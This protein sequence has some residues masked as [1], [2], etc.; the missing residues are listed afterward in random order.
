[1][2]GLIKETNENLKAI[3]NTM[4]ENLDT[5]TYSL[6][7]LQSQM[8]KKVEEAKKYKIQVDNAKENIKRIEEDNTNL[9][10]SLNELTD[11]YSKLN[12]VNII[13]AGN[14]EIK[15]KINENIKEIN[16]N[17][18]HIA[19]LTNKAR[20][21]KDLLINLK[22]DKNIK[23]ERLENLRIAYEFY[24][25]NLNEIIE[26]TYNNPDSLDSLEFHNYNIDT[27]ETEDDIT[28]EI[29]DY[30]DLEN[31]MVFEEIA[32]IDENN[33]FKDETSYIDDENIEEEHYSDEEIEETDEER[34]NEETI[35]NDEYDEEQE[36]IDEIKEN[37]DFEDDNVTFE[38]NSEVDE[39]KDIDEDSNIKRNINLEAVDSTKTIDEFITPDYT[40]DEN[41][42]DINVK[43]NLDKEETEDKE[44]DIFTEQIEEDSA[45]KENI[46]KI[47]APTNNLEIEE[48]NFNFD[49][50]G[51]NELNSEVEENN[52]YN[53]FELEDNS[54]D[55]TGNTRINEISN[56]LTNLENTK[57][58]TIEIDNIEE[59]INNAINV[60]EKNIIE[61]QTTTTLTD[62][63]GNPIKAE[64]IDTSIKQ[65]KKI[66]EIFVENGVDFNKFKEDEQNYLNQIYD[67]TKFIEIFNIL[68]KYKI[69]VDNLYYSFNIFG[70]IG[71]DELDTIITKLINIGQSIETIGMILEKMPKIKKYNLD[72][73]I[74]SYN[75]EIKNVNITELI[76]RAK[77][78]YNNGGNK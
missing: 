23:E 34:F 22:K 44:E 37:N 64:E 54:F 70:E 2:N 25:K 60:T 8:D 3:I 76:M 71:S 41:F 48:T 77:E 75:D 27:T 19:E 66:E 5:A 50:N 14:K 47:E 20:T 61:D 55:I 72:A 32:F 65:V 35:L 11:K 69:N 10:L 13:E 30:S 17:R 21:I 67:E 49:I 59:K 58:E 4:K 56:L 15:F 28:E 73:A 42:E 52:D 29:K 24:S 43:L 46:F 74:T 12:L 57:T 39:S 31:T 36:E 53:K 68:N 33:A 38:S 16:K 9:E 6:E 51:I 18:E 1:M 78:L 7:A 63:F 45:S 40:F 26:Y 62:I